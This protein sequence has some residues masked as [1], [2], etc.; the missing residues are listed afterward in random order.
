MNER[1]RTRRSLLRVGGVTAVGALA[2]CLSDGNGEEPN[3]EEDNDGNEGG[4]DQPEDEHEDDETGDETTGTDETD[5]LEQY[6][7]Y[8]ERE[9]ITVISLDEKDGE[10]TIEIEYESDELDDEFALADEIGRISGGFM[11]R[12]E[13]G[14]DK[15]RL[16]ATIHDDAGEVATWYMNAEWFVELQEGERTPEE[17]SG[18][19][20]QTVEFL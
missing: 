20:L 3:D 14:W 10:N 6:D 15:Q 7:S 17:L 9:D 8:L 12:L 4:A 1:V 11:Q 16:E 13:A 2:G 18:E 5:H 19:I